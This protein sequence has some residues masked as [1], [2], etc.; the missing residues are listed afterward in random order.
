MLDEDTKELVRVLNQPHRV[1]NMLALFRFC[2]K[3]ATI[4]QDQAAELDKLK[5]KPAPKSKKASTD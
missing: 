4:I 2:E 1:S 5:A 3:A